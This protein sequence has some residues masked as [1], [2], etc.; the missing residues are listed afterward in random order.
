MEGRRGGPGR[1]DRRS[2]NDRVT[3]KALLEHGYRVRG[4]ERERKRESESESSW[5]AEWCWGSGSTAL[6]EEGR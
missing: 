1:D 3:E 4:K 6:E 5:K 2:P